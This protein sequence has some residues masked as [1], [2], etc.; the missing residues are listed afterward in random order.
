MKQF[1]WII[2]LITIGC[3]EKVTISVPPGTGKNL[4]KALI[5]VKPG[6]E[7]QLQEGVYE[8]SK[9]LTLDVENITITGQGPK[10]TILSFK[11][12]KVGA[13]GFLVT[14]GKFKIRNL[15]IEDSLGDALKIKGVKDI[16][17]SSIRVEWLGEVKEGNGAYG[18]YPVECEN[19]VI[20]N[21]F[22]RGASDAGI[23]VGQSKNI[24]VSNNH[25]TE[26]VA[27]IEIENSTRADVFK[28]KVHN[29]TGGILVFDLPN[30]P[31][32]GGNRVRVFHND[33]K[34]NNHHNF[35]AKGTVVANVPP[36]TG[37]MVMA[38]DY[39]EIFSNQIHGH[40]T[41]SIAIVSYHILNKKWQDKKYDPYPQAIYIHRNKIS[42]SGANPSG[43]LGKLVA[44]L[45]EKMPDIIWDGMVN[46]QKY[47]NGKLPRN[48][49]IF[50]ENNGHA[51]FGNFNL[52]QLQ[53]GTANVSTNI[54]VH[55]GK[56][57]A[58]PQVRVK[59][60]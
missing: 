48:M 22:V 7:I 56:I 15:A 37:V 50:I 29:N 16:H 8:F 38:N 26:N 18:L 46:T 52:Q 41:S 6:T 44:P 57:P 35:A 10:K 4:Q 36:G 2:A 9:R 54:K 24:I 14:K 28:N 31:I 1:I 55:R 33:L 34:D 60:F 30:L 47:P 39:V 45:F 58:L 19:I 42:R 13:E 21:C 5:E 32:Q 25:V 49:G 12:Q 51:T 17:L 23:Y 40:N 11:K 53:R 59:G 20:D 43:A 3:S 27:G